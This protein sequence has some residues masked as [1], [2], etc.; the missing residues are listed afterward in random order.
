MPD[1]ALSSSYGP[2]SQALKLE[3]PANTKTRE[4]EH[5]ALIVGCGFG[6]MG[7]AIQ[8]QRMG[9]DDIVMLDRATDLG[10][11]W[12]LNSY[13]GLAVDIASVTYSYSFEPNPHWTR[14]YA[15][16]AELKAYANRVAEK[17][18]L[19]RFMRFDSAV[20]QVV[21]D[22]ANKLWT[23][24]V[25][26]QRPITTRILILAT[27]YLS[28]PQR[29]KIPGIDSFAGKV[30]HTAAWDHGY[31]LHGKRAAVIGTGATAVQLIPE[32]AP[33]LDKLYVHQRTAIWVA[34]KP[35][36]RIPEWRRQLYAHAPFVQRIL[37]WVDAFFL[38]IMVMA[39]L[40]YR[41]VPWMTQ[42][43]ERTCKEHIAYWIKDPALREKLTPKYAFGCKRPTFSNSYYRT[44]TK[45]NVELVTET[46]ERIEPDG[47]VTNDGKK[48]EI[49]VLVL[50]TG[51]SVWER[52]SFHSIIG[53]NGVEL[54]DFWEQ[55]R[56]QA[57]E[58]ITIPGF[59]NLFN[60]PSP[61]SYT[62]LSY[63]N[64]IEGQ[65]KHLAR[66]LTAMKRKNAKSFEVRK[67]AND[68]FLARMSQRFERSAFVLGR[69]GGANSYYFDKHGEPSLIRPTGVL[70][71]DYRH[72]TFPLEDYCFE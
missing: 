41:Q 48:R 53:K 19:R 50:A 43:A 6:G 20:E 46:I 3:H 8:L 60:L 57:Y 37:R 39:V 71:A 59:P 15:P 40:R 38:E 63:F 33:Q 67:E 49:D 58:G 14:R 42:V 7:M 26:G 27:G 61:Y 65:M 10:G 25:E 5:Q 51:F 18:G 32:I 21:Y 66:C 64:T 29:P 13:P 22:E 1:A 24:H 35:D 72:A 28:R 12:H 34:P 54:R 30:I 45:P 36:Q 23:V 17:Y 44:F 68:A 70:S 56:Y 4:P 55:N 47:I 31:D 62:G 69:C 2:T 9:I 11:T 16:G 52:D